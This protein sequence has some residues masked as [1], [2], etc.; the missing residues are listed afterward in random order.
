MSL[1]ITAKL[2]SKKVVS[3]NL[4]F[5]KGELTKCVPCAFLSARNGHDLGDQDSRCPGAA[6]GGGGGTCEKPLGGVGAGRAPPNLPNPRSPEQASWVLDSSCPFYPLRQVYR[7]V[8]PNPHCTVHPSE[9]LLPGPRSVRFS[10]ARPWEEDLGAH[11]RLCE[12]LLGARGALIWPIY[13]EPVS[14]KVGAHVP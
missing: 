10:M 4:Q 12:G 5:S 13:P 9:S 14:C 3:D 6:P 7:P 8:T 2:L 11:T 1:G